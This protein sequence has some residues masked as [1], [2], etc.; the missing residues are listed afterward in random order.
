MFGCVGQDHH[1]FVFGLGTPKDGIKHVS[2]DTHVNI[3]FYFF[4]LFLHPL[5][6]PLSTSVLPPNG[7]P[8]HPTSSPPPFRTRHPSLHVPFTPP[9]RPFV[10]P[11][12]PSAPPHLA[13][14]SLMAN[15]RGGPLWVLTVQGSTHGLMDTMHGGHLSKIQVR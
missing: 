15:A 4:F 12:W 14:S 2:W 7:S 3:Y 8:L 13:L 11:R 6:S 1:C 9:C 10:P 5:F